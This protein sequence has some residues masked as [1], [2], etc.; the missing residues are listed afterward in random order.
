ML[1]YRAHS[2][3]AYARRDCSSYPC[4]VGKEGIKTAIAAIVEIDIDPAVKDEN[5]VSDCVGALNGERVTVKGGEEPG[6]FCSNEFAGFFV[7]PELFF[8]SHLSSYGGDQN[9]PCIHNPH[10]N[11]CMIAALPSIVWE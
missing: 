3:V 11:L 7:R 2:V 5:E 1:R 6:V 9:I 10:A 4:R 8:I